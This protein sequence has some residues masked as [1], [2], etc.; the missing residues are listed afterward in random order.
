MVITA[1]LCHIIK[2]NRLLLKRASRGISKGKW[3]AP[4][5]KLTGNESPL[6]SAK[7]EVLEETG[8]KVK[9]AIYHGTMD[10][11]LSGSKAVH[12][13]AYLFSTRNFEGN[14]RSTSEG[15][16][17]WFAQND[18]PFNQMWPDDRYWIPL[19]LAGSKFDATFFFDKNNSKVTRYTIISQRPRSPQVMRHKGSPYESRKLPRGVLLA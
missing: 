8:L 14:Y 15:I 19:M 17:K 16:L 13:R 11:Y 6:Q 10:Y 5:G 2:R 9:S 4:G 7:R 3:N 1:T 18:L 12:T